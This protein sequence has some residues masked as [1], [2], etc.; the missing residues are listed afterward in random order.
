MELEV[1]PV[2]PTLIGQLQVPDSDAMNRE[3]RELI[4]AEEKKHASLGR[5][6]IGG[7]HSRP[8]FLNGSEASVGALTAWITWAVKN[9]VHASAGPGAF[10]GRISLAA[11][12]TTCR[13]GAYHALGD[14]SQ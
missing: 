5:S 3:L 4:L 8:D 10:N 6:N 1:T 13:D 2:F 9:M 7:W 12:A 14:S 11:W